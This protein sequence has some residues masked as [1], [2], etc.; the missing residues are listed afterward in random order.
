MWHA[1]QY[2]PKI[3][4]NAEQIYLNKPNQQVQTRPL[5]ASPSLLELLSVTFQSSSHFKTWNVSF[6]FEESHSSL[7]SVYGYLTWSL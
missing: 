7:R 5:N 3:G 6:S 2:P 1:R 4:F